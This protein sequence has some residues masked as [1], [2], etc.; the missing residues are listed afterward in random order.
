MAEVPHQ[1]RTKTS[2]TVHK[3]TAENQRH[4]QGLG[5][6]GGWQRQMPVDSASPAR[7]KV[8]DNDHGKARGFL[9][10]WPDSQDIRPCGPPLVSATWVFVLFL[11]PLKSTE[12]V[13][14]GY[15]HD[16]AH[17]PSSVKPHVCSVI[18][19]NA[20]EV[21]D[22]MWF[23]ERMTRRPTCSSWPGKSLLF[24]HSLQKRP[25]AGFCHAVVR[26]V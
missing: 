3:G 7:A 14:S 26:R 17:R 2:I 5:R 6:P 4:P 12:S 21:L 20:A 18:H 10:K 16:L 22:G 19:I 11:Q 23:L 13:L 24:P 8:V 9:R 25:S 1:D 15:R